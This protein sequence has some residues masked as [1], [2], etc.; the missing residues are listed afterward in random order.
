MGAEGDMMS[1]CGNP[2]AVPEFSPGVAFRDMVVKES[3][4][5]R[6]HPALQNARTRQ[7]K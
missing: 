4:S 3:K 7:I 2:A 5:A 6:A 1:E